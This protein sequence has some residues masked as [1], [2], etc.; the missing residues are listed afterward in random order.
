MRLTP[1][2]YEILHTLYRYDG[3]L[4][5]DQ[6]HRWFFGVKR[7]AYYRIQALCE[8]HCL[9]RL[10][11]Q[12]RFRVPEAIVWLDK[13]GAQVLADYVGLEYTDLHWRTQPRWSKV[14]HDL[15]LNEFRHIF[16]EALQVNPSYSLEQ[17]LGQDELER[18]LTTPLSYL[19]VNGVTQKKLI[20]PDGYLTMQVTSE[21]PYLLRFLIELDNNTTSSQRFGRDKVSP[22]IHFLRSETYK[23]VLNG[24]SGRVLV[25][26][27]GSRQRFDTL[28]TEVM[29]AGGSSYFLFVRSEEWQTIAQ[30]LTQPLLYLAHQATPFSFAEYHTRKSVV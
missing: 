17:W 2:D 13:T 7:R 30:V 20:R 5:V 15:A 14:S 12:E 21:Q 29:R 25:V 6:I 22:L 8:Q 23:R 28:R 9:Q 11:P 24:K 27:V 3:V 19:D 16:E 10:T 1:R 18:A 26:A 4:S